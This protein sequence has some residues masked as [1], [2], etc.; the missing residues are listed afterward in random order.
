MEAGGLN[1]TF[2]SPNVVV[3][4]VDSVYD[5]NS[6]DCVYAQWYEEEW[7]DYWKIPIG[8]GLVVHC[9]LDLETEGRQCDDYDVKL[10]WKSVNFRRLAPK[11]PSD[12]MQGIT[13]IN[14]WRHMIQHR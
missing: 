5:E 14:G 6:D 1:V 10:V 7:G 13:M 2:E 11:N 12:R 8:S 4:S 9:L 3:Y